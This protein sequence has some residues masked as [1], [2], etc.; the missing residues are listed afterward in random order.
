LAELR[1]ELP[2]ILN[3]ALEGYRA[4]KAGGL[5]PPPSVL[6]STQEYKLENEIAS[7]KKNLSAAKGRKM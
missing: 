4:W 7:L 3:W 1:A 5:Q 6:E 2:G